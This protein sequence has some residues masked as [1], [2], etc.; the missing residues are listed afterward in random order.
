MELRML[1][2]GTL[3][4]FVLIAGVV[5]YGSPVPV[6]AEIQATGAENPQILKSGQDSTDDESLN[7]TQNAERLLRLEEALRSDT[8]R[9]V[10]LQQ[11]LEQRVE[12][13]DD[14]TSRKQ[15]LEQDLEEKK[16][17]FG[18]RKAAGESVDESAFAV[19]VEKLEQR[20]ALI[21][22]QSENTFQGAKTLQVQIKSLEEKIGKDQRAIEQLTG[23]LPDAPDKQPGAV[24]SVETR[25]EAAETPPDS[26][27]P[28]ILP[29]M[30]GKPATPQEEAVETAPETAQQIEARQDA[31]KT[32][33]QARQAELAVVDF[34]E[35]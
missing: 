29:G 32:A 26:P 14:L 11:E 25:G 33:I 19:E 18:R 31:E 9:L 4:L 22:K 5:L 6:N 30:P 23:V 12:M 3:R 35:R 10:Q 16:K 13:F 21:M 20:H 17:E 2:S 24:E 8:E 15:S 7:Q 34:L 27:L 28:G 1:T